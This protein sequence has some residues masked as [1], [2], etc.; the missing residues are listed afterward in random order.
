VS[1]LELALMGMAIMVM[2]ALVVGAAAIADILWEE[3]E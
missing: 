2:A 1:G 3:D